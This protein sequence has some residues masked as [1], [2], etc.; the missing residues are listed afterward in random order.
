METIIVGI[1]LVVFEIIV[2]KVVSSNKKATEQIRNEIKLVHIKHESWVE[3]YSYYEGNGL[4]GKYNELVENK[5]S[6]SQFINTVQ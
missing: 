2:L 3:A 6:D 5:K 1:V 4:L